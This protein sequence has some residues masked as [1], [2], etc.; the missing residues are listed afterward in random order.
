MPHEMSQ[1]LRDF[2]LV[3]FVANA[4]YTYRIT[5]ETVGELDVDTWIDLYETDGETFIAENDDAE[6]GRA[7]LTWE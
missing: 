5:T 1:D 3:W 6:P 7:Q 4:R 2:R